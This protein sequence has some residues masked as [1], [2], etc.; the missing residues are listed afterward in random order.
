MA[1]RRLSLF[2][3]RI[4]LASVR[5]WEPVTRRTPD[6]TGQL[7]AVAS[8]VVQSPQFPWLTPSVSRPDLS[9]LLLEVNGQCG[10]EDNDVD[11]EEFADRKQQFAAK[12]KQSPLRRQRRS[13]PTATPKVWRFAN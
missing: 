12:A 10:I 13:V 4:F 8:R 7:N 6:P 5:G 1:H 3:A 2:Q 11:V 9:Q